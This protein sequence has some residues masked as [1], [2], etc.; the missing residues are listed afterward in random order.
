MLSGY[1]FGTIPVVRDNF[2][3]VVLAIIAI[4][5]MPMVVQFVRARRASPA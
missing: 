3:I 4:S 5:L 1:F 2:S